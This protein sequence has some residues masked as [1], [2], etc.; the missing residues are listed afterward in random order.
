ML[1]KYCDLA[2]LAGTAA[3]DEAKFCEN[4]S[5]MKELLQNGIMPVKDK[6]KPTEEKYN[7]EILGSCVSRVIMLNGKQTEHGMDNRYIKMNHFFD[8]N[9][10]VFCMMPA[11]FPKEEVESVKASEL[12]ESSRIHSLKQCLDKSTVSLILNGKSDYLILDFY[13]FEVTH[14]IF[15]NTAFS[16]CA[17]EFFTT[18]L[19][20]KHKSEITTFNWKDVPKFLYYPYIDL[21]FEKISE[22]YDNNHIILNRFRAT[23]HY[24]DKQNK[25]QPIP[26]KFLQ[27]FHAN[28]HYNETVRNLE[29]YIIDKY[30]PYVIDLSKYFVGDEHLWDNLNGAHFQKIFYEESFQIIKDI[31]FGQPKQKVFDGL[32]PKAVTEI[33]ETGLCA[34]E[35]EKYLQNVSN[36]FCTG[37]S[38]DEFVSQLS[39]EKIA[40]NQEKIADKYRK[41]CIDT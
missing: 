35:F 31:I 2:Y 20:K 19:F 40:Q 34:D 3:E 28:Y 39:M 7:V 27:P 22:K 33:L 26:E 23:S 5:E 36:P 21:F 10:I 4:V 32:T 11:P 37:L 30:H 41:F 1:E 9:N 17:N 12:W 13:D 24:I 29:N 38:V 8:K 6:I 15:R 18:E 16:T 14:A 25:V